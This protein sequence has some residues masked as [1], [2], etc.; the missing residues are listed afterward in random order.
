L[1]AA[2][3][4]A[5]KD[6]RLRI[7]DRSAIIIGIVA[8]LALAFIFNLVFGGA[9]ESGGV[10]LSYGIV[11]GDGSEIS[12]ALTEVLQG[13]EE[14]GI[15]TV[16]SFGDTASADEAIESG[17]ID[18]YFL[19]PEGFEQEVI[20]GGGPILEV[21]GNVDEPT[22]TEIAYS[23]ADQFGMGLESARLAVATTAALSGA[24]VTPELISSLHGDPANAAFSYALVDDAVATR[25]LDGTTYFAAAMAVFFLFFTVQF[26]V[27]GLLEEERDGTL[28][29]LL[30][31][32]VARATVVGGKA[33]LAFVLGVVSMTVLV[34]GTQVLMGAQWGAPLGVTLL[35]V[36]GVLSAVGIMGL[37]A[38]GAKTAEGAGNLGSIIAVILGM[39]GGVFFPI[40]G[41]GD[42]L[43]RLT[44]ITPHAWF[45]RGLGDLADGARWTSA[46]PATGAM[47]V[48]ALITGLAAWLLLRRRLLA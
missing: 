19:V 23:I 31:A 26:G 25:Q 2:G 43:S 24:A 33:L 20:N 38:A 8:P 17:E 40:G 12:A 6:L 32:P 18:A 15:L 34:T 11:D 3:R 42:L 29:R 5:A 9:F 22:A 10:E 27:L 35:V 14:E 47:L 21:I 44:Y 41:S 39:L 45:L 30:A 36:G 13:A 48:F 37:V 16:Q 7:R 28:P 46:L 4:I 1:K